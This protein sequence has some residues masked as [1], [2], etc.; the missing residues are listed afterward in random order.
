MSVGRRAASACGVDNRGGDGAD[1]A[2]PRISARSG[3]DPARVCGT[4]LTGGTVTD[5]DTVWRVFFE[6]SQA[7]VRAEGLEQKLRL[8]ARAVVD[9]GLF[10]RALVQIYAQA[11]GTKIFGS[12][13]LSTEEED[14]IREHD[15]LTPDVYNRVQRR[16]RH[17]GGPVYFIAHDMLRDI[18]PNA[19]EVFLMGQTAWAGPGFWH[20][21]DM[22]YCQLTSSEGVELGN[23][24]ADEP[25]DGRI[26]DER[27]AR[28]LGPFVSLAA[29]MVE[30][31]INRRRDHL[32][33]CFEGRV[34][35]EE[36]ARRLKSGRRFGVLFC[37]M[38]HLKTIN[39]EEG[40]HAGDRAIQAAADHLR[41]AA[42][43]PPLATDWVGRL[44]GDEFLVIYWLPERASEDP[45]DQ[46]EESAW[47]TIR[48]R[49]SRDV[50]GV[51]VG[52]ALARPDD[53]VADLIRRAEL[54]MYEDK[55]RR[56]R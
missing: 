38:D 22:L 4:L 21:D 25:G 6:Q 40:H 43:T 2:R 20:P 55:R 36:I 54:R 15:V 13:G 14:W 3:Q 29:A 19:D 47:E 41:A 46:D 48:R 31:E 9:T 11:Y 44:H 37:D 23:L 32:T 28:L 26:P 39:D 52:L 51:S 33:G 1:V 18:F 56:R 42:A 12:A 50:P 24:T 7:I 45:R 10:R 34:C 49:W 17:L 5:T 8:V 35:R 53:T 27:T 16:A 30:Q